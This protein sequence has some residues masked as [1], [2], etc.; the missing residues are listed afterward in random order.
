MPL[1]GLEVIYKSKTLYFTLEN[2]NLPKFVLVSFLD[3]QLSKHVS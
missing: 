2:A 3:P 1:S